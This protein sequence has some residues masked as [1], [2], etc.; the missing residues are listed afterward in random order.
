LERA[1]GFE[2]SAQNSQPLQ[3]QNHP[4]SADSDYT[5]IRAQILGV[6]GPELSQVVASWSKLPAPLKAAILAIVGSVT[7]SKEVES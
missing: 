2:P 4:Q 1:K 6:L 3:P 5:Q 7:S